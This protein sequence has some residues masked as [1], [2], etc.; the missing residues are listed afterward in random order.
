[1]LSGTDW[2]EGGWNVDELTQ[3]AP[4]LEERGVDLLDI[5]SAGLH[6]DQQIPVGPGYQLRFSRAVRQVVSIPVATV[7][8]IETAKQAESAIVDDAADV[9]LLGRPFLR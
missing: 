7:G 6:P 3:V 2:V 5:S 4:W 8:L 1:R 9:V